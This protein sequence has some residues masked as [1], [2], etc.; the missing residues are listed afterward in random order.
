MSAQIITGDCLDIMRGMEAGT[1]DAI[2]TDP[3]YCSGARRSADM[4]TRGGMSPGKKWNDAPI[5]SDLMTAPGYTWLMRAVA[6]EARRLLKP[7]GWLVVFVDWRQYPALYGVIESAN[8][9]VSGMLV[10][11]K[12]N[13]GMGPAF[14]NQHELA[15][16]ASVGTGKA[17]SHS[18]GNV[19]TVKRLSSSAVHPTEKPVDLMRP[20]LRVVC[21][22]G[23]LVLD[24]F[25]GSGT[26]GAAALLEGMEFIGI[27]RAPEYA[28]P[29]R[30]R[31][32]ELEGEA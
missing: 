10:W 25:A 13:F 26:T 29:A 32:A 12:V 20:I 21:P 11:D 1:I 27:E 22:S 30:A 18:I 5:D 17:Y 9:R 8:L 4:A 16:V 3:P 19:L 31:L 2:V 15:I 24:P 23:G 6:L 28:D 14:R 7:G